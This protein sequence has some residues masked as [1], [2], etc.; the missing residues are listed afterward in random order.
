ML[1]VLIVKI[2]FKT[3]FWDIFEWKTEKGY[4]DD[5]IY[6]LNHF[7]KLLLQVL[8]EDGELISGI[9]CKKSL[10]PSAGSIQNVVFLEMGFEAAGK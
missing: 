4:A 8:V 7:K 2:K 9:L 10:G 3:F 6:K 1:L 5:I